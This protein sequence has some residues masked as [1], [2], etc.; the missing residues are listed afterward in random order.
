[1]PSRRTVL[2]TVGAVTVAD[3]TA[4][5]RFGRTDP[6]PP[7]QF[8]VEPT[9]W[10][11]PDH[12]PGNTNVVPGSA[13]PSSFEPS[14]DVTFEENLYDPI[15]APVVADGVLYVVVTGEHPDGEFERLVALDAVTGEERWR[16]EVVETAFPYPPAVAGETVYWVASADT[17]LA[18]NAA[19]GSV[20]WTYD[21]VNHQPPVLAHGLVL[22]AGGDRDDPTLEALDPHTGRRYW[23]RRETDT[24]WRCLGADVTSVYVTRN[25][26]GDDQRS[27][28]LS[29][30]PQSGRTQ[31]STPRITSRSA[32]IGADYI[33]ASSDRPDAR[34]L[35]AFHKPTREIRWTERRDLQREAEGETVNGQQRV[36]AVADDTAL[37][38]VAFHGYFDDRIEARDPA[39]GAVRW[40]FTRETGA[41]DDTGDAVVRFGSPIVVGQR[42]YVPA[43]T[44]PSDEEIDDETATLHVRELATG[45]EVAR[46]DLAEPAAAKPVVADG[47]LYLRTATQLLTHV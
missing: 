2:A 37:V 13:A 5:P 20:R 41:A 23:N 4:L 27:E 22:V 3:C 43:A 44:D 14:W 28:L 9:D 31:W 47:R 35:V 24:R 18:L 36:A 26:D 11:H 40:R 42:V 38:H 45:A 29:L 15:T 8:L 46:R 17:V 10:A 39:T 7:T 25:P 34:E 32:T 6:D 21:A 12:D 30:D 33:Y 19:D 16:H 1:M